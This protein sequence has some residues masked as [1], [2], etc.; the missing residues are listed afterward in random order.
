MENSYLKVL[1]VDDDEDDYIVTEELLETAEIA[2]FQL[3]WIDTYSEALEVM[4]QKRHDI[5]L[6]DYRLGPE[7]GLELL[8]EAINRGVSA[9]IILLTGL[10]DHQ[11]DTEAMKIGAADYL[12][13]D[14]M[15]TAILERSILHALERKQ[16]DAKQDRLIAELEEANRELKNLA[17]FISQDLQVPLRALGSLAEFLIAYYGDKLDEK[18]KNMLLLIKKNVGRMKRKIDNLMNDS[19]CK[20]MVEEK[21]ED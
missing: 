8:K 13:K 11:I 6:L 14:Q 9:P 5:Y 20:H 19:R 18:G 2:L 16:I 1:L 3:D 12:I 17:D 21:A 15:D 4:G 10:G 7:T